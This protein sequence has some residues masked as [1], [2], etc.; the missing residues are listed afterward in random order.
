MTFTATAQTQAASGQQIGA[1][2]PATY[3]IGTIT[4]RAGNDI[5]DETTQFS[6]NVNGLG[7]QNFDIAQALTDAGI[8]SGD[9]I[10]KT[11]FVTAMQ[12]TINQ[13][14][15]LTGDNAVTVA[16]VLRTGNNDGCRP[17]PGRLFLRTRSHSNQRRRRRLKRS[18]PQTITVADDEITI[19]D[20]GFV[21]GDAVAYANGGG[22]DLGGLTGGT[23]YYV[24]RSDDDTIQLA[25]SEAN[26]FAGTAITLTGTGNAAQ[27]LTKAAGDGM[28]ATLTQ[29]TA[30]T[31][32]SSSETGTG[33]SI[34]LGASDNESSGDSAV[35]G[36]VKP[37]GITN[38]VIAGATDHT[39]A[40]TDVD[41]TNDTVT[42]TSHGYV[43]G[44][45]LTYDDAGGTTLGGLADD[46][47][48]WVIRE[49]ANTIKLASSYANAIAG[50]AITL[51]GTGNASQTLTHSNDE[52]T[53]AINGG[54]ATTLDIADDTYYTL[55]Q[56]ATAIQTA[57]DDSP[58]AQTG[59][60]PIT[61]SVTTDSNG[62]QGIT[63]REC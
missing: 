18:R 27:T 51:T 50:T 6:L 5:G 62:D 31:D 4:T 33:G 14:G 17:V 41:T 38:R 36:P 54:A 19:T 49:D 58:F 29:E 20:H 3:T 32:G 34:V 23:T 45:K 26:A 47:E 43:T 56:L 25:S 30:P 22:A 46:T 44:Q 39:I 59:S 8:S 7:R 16:V 55:D 63:F 21:T 9:A 42:I 60:F 12:A 52:F 57:I 11:Q 53:M 35:A 28:A 13:I 40:T 2:R 48:Y 1:F 10:T 15:Q 37:F 24:I 61:V